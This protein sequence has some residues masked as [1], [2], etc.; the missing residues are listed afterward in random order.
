MSE[1]TQPLPADPLFLGMTRPALVW[2]VP[3]GGFVAN[4]ALTTILF[5]AAADLRAFLIFLPIHAGAYLLCLRD[6]RVFDLLL[7]RAAKTPPIPNV[8]FWKAKSY[9]P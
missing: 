2:G 9:A 6:P 5:L 4:A 1:P 8:A 7:V 3:F